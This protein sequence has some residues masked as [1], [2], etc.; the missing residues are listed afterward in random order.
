MKSA[1]LVIDV[2]RG[3]FDRVPPPADADATIARINALTSRG[4]KA[5][6]PVIYVQHGAQYA[7]G[8]PP[9]ELDPR[10]APDPRDHRVR[11][12]TPD[13][14]HRTELGDLLASLGVKSL[15]I[16]GYATEGCVDSTVRRAAALGYDVTIAADA[17]TTDDKPHASAARIR[18]HHNA[19][20]SDLTSF[21]G[22]IAAIDS[23]AIALG[24]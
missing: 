21:E 9:W 6:V 14:F 7:S 8:T 17:H 18:E 20:L 15:I 19:A 5:G 23:A 2:Q 4:R 16:C 24:G 3:Y 10:L 11:K 13:S 12:N 1:I 22:R